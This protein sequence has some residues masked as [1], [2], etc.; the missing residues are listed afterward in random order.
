VLECFQ[1]ALTVAREHKALTCELR[2][3][4]RLVRLFQ[5]EGG[6][7][8]SELAQAVAALDRTYGRFTE[9]WSFPD[10]RDAAELIG[11][12]LHR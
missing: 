9:G 2:T 12:A 6:S 4:M 1:V 11:Q 10:L 7:R 3:L 5:S 8:I